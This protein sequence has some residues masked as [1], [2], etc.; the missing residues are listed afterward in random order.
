MSIFFDILRP[1][2]KS[3]REGMVFRIHVRAPC[4]ML[5][6]ARPMHDFLSRDT[7]RRWSGEDAGIQLFAKQVVDVLAKRKDDG[8]GDAREP[9]LSEMATASFSVDPAAID[10][11]VARMLAA[12]V[13]P[14]AIVDHYIP[15]VARRLGKEWEDDT[16]GFVDVTIGT[17]R[18]QAVLRH[19]TTSLTTRSAASDAAVRVL[20]AVPEG[21]DHTLGAMVVASRLRRDGHNVCLRL[22][23]PLKELQGLTRTCRF[24]AVLVSAANVERLRQL[25]AMIGALKSELPDGAPVLL[26]GAIAA[27]EGDFAAETGADAMTAD[28][29]TVV[30]HLRDIDEIKCARQRA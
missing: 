30:D 4:P 11:V 29:E 16:R 27:R 9:F 18:L 17:A 21:E 1:V 23:T 26:G 13:P 15:A 6:E 10:A 14:I 25:K 24:D 3:R 20:V 28:I 12:R 5:A 22:Q 7:S 19:L 8:R 2:G